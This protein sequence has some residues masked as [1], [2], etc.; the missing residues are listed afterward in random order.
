MTRPTVDS[1]YIHRMSRATQL[2]T[3]LSLLLVPTIIY[4]GL[5]L[6]GVIRGGHTGRPDRRTSPPS[7]KRSTGRVTR[8]PA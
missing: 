8:T 4:G 7:S 2:M 5:T 6:L 1:G 3:G